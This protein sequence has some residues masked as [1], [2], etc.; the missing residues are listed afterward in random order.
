[1]PSAA[2]SLIDIIHENDCGG[3]YR[4]ASPVLYSTHI[5]RATRVSISGFSSNTGKTSLLCDLLNLNRGWEAIKVSRGHYRSCGKSAQACCISPLLGEKPLILSDPKDTLVAGKDTGRYWQSGASQVQWLICTSEQLEEGIRLALAS[6]RHEGV[7]IEGTSF[8]KY[9]A[10]DYSIM[11]A[12]PAGEIKSSAAR[13][14]E[15][16]DAIFIPGPQPDFDM[17]SSLRERL[18]KRGADLK[19]VPVFFSTARLSEKIEQVHQARIR[20]EANR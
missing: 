8:L 15:K 3:K 10:V 17:R 6:V 1:M 7:F 11:V 18:Q 19:D 5:M 9:E 16:V 14:I 2:N 13:V 12:S 4:L 20:S